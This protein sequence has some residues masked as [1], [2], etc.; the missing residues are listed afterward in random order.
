MPRVLQYLVA[1]FPGNTESRTLFPFGTVKDIPTGHLHHE[2]SE[3]GKGKASTMDE[4][5]DLL[6]LGYLKLRIKTVVSALL[7]DG[8]DKPLLFIFPNT[9]LGKVN[10]KGNLV[11]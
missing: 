8:L 4:A 7:P 5:V 3:A 10:H 11:D 2:V 6:Y 1:W 9:F